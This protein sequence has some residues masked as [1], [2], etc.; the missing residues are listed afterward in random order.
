M[1]AYSYA[2]VIFLGM[3]GHF[4]IIHVCNSLHV[5]VC[6]CAWCIYNFHSVDIDL[7]IDFFIT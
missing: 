2:C 3:H 7:G 5:H 6:V 4:N 1:C